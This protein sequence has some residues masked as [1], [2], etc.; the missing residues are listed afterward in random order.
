MLPSARR[1]VWCASGGYIRPSPML[2]GGG[3]DFFGIPLSLSSTFLQCSRK[4]FQSGIRRSHPRRSGESAVKFVEALAYRRDPYLHQYTTE[5][6][7][8][9]NAAF[10]GPATVRPL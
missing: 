1:V 4:F 6:V 8:A 2:G 5:D 3:G 9:D 10:L 7:S